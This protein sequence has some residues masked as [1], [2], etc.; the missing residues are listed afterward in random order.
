[1]NKVT[2]TQTELNNLIGVYELSP[3]FSI[4]ITNE[5][6]QLVIQATA[7]PKIPFETKSTSEF[8]NAM[9]QARIVF[10][11]DATGTATSLTLFQAGQALKGIRK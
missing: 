5:N 6:D 1:V 10:E 4:T 3:N 2:L 8:I 9:V 7:Q 11:L